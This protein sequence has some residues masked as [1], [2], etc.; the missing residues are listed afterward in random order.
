MDVKKWGCP[1][2]DSLSKVKDGCERSSKI[3]APSGILWQWHH[4]P[5]PMLNVRC[6]IFY[7]LFFNLSVISLM[8]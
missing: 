1:K 3:V 8:L 6:C 2:C 4:I 7:P 5:L